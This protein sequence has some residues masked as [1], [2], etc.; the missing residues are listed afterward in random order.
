VSFDVDDVEPGDRALK[1]SFEVVGQPAVAV[2]PRESAS[3]QP[4]SFGS[5]AA[6]D[7]LDDP[8]SEIHHCRFRRPAGM[9]TVDE[10]MAQPAVGVADRLLGR[11]ITIL[12]YCRL[13]NGTNQQADHV[14][15]DAP[16]AD[17]YHLLCRITVRATIFRRLD[18][19]AV[20]D[21]GVILVP[22][23][24]YCSRRL[25]KQERSLPGPTTQPP[26]CF[27]EDL[28]GSLRSHFVPAL[29]VVRLCLPSVP[30]TSLALIL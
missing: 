29:K 23:S 2:E 25:R 3:D 17:H 11:L 8:L 19:L 30:P 6:A 10:Q 26:D 16:L 12:H 18:Q 15:N 5:I 13:R 27:T 20:N 22:R 24:W 1:D 28:A 14:D 7:D 21:A 4:S 9:E